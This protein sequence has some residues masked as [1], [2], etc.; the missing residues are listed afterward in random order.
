MVRP[1]SGWG[2]QA[3]AGQHALA[4]CQ[5]GVRRCSA[6]MKITRG[7]PFAVSHSA[8]RGDGVAIRVGVVTT[9]MIDSGRL[10]GW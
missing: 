6:A 9:K 5:A 1:H 4:R 7:G 10:R 2:R 8:G 3:A